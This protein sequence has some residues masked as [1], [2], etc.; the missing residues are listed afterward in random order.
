VDQSSKNGQVSAFSAG[1]LRVD[2]VGDLLLPSSSAVPLRD[3]REEFRAALSRSERGA[4]LVTRTDGGR[5]THQAWILKGPG[6]AHLEAAFADY[7]VS[8]R[9][10]LVHGVVAD[11]DAPAEQPFLDEVS[12]LA[13]ARYPGLE[14]L[15]AAP[16]GDAISDR[17]LKIGEI[18][19]RIAPHTATTASD[20]VGADSAAERQSAS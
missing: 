17:L 12:T 5:L 18:V 6:Q 8:D 13:R 15:V 9:S 1:E 2:E 4:Q 3:R 10:V 7:E 16:A 20:E 14:L 19:E 11:T